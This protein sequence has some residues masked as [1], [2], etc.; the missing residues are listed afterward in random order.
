[1]KFKIKANKKVGENEIE[2][3]SNDAWDVMQYIEQQW[4]QKI[5]NEKQDTTTSIW[6]LHTDND[7]KTWKYSFSV[8]D[9]YVTLGDYYYHKFIM[10]EPKGGSIKYTKQVKVHQ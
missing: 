7:G 4:R 1:M 2:F 3:Q 9:G 8:E 5:P 10:H 6:N